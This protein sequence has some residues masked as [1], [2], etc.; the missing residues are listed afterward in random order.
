MSKNQKNYYIFLFQEISKLDPDGSLM[1]IHIFL[2]LNPYRYV[3]VVVMV[4]FDAYTQTYRNTYVAILEK[5]ENAM[6]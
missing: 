2:T 6:T 5:T 3:L 1:S 4:V